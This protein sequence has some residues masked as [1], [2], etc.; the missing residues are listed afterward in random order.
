MAKMSDRHKLMAFVLHKEFGYRQGAIGQLMQV[1]QSTI[2]NA[3][4][5][6]SFRMTIQNLERE[7][8]E[9]RYLLQEQGIHPEIPQL[10]IDD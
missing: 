1:S 3:V 10:F 9:T 7:L 8:Q 5:E 6:V 2:A 4:K